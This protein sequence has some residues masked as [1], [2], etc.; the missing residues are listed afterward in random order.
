MDLIEPTA[1]QRHP[2]EVRRAAFFAGV[3]RDALVGRRGLD[4]LDCGAGDAYFSG[5][6]RDAVPGIQSITCY[7]PNYDAATLL[8]L[9]GTYPSLAFRQSRPKQTFSVVLML[10]VL[11]HVDDDES[12]LHDIVHE[13]VD[14]ESLVLVSVPAWPLLSTRH[15]EFLAHRRRYS[16]SACDRLL[17]TAGLEI[18]KRGGA[19]HSLV[20]P[21]AATALREAVAALRAPLPAL[22]ESTSSWNHGFA[23]TSV[24]T[25]ALHLDNLT[26]RVF[27][28]AGVNVP[29]LT[30]WALARRAQRGSP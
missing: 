21:R 23:L 13:C 17:G 24:V 19:F 25:A 16:P 5:G 11:E 18:L 15:D 20:F 28:R 12:F 6:L 26:S 3:L 2:W 22:A 30:Y 8:R 10:D 29:G 7:D 27:A 1:G 9:G 14:G 4:V